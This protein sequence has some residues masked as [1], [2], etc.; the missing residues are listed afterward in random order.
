MQRILFQIVIPRDVSTFPQRTLWDQCYKSAFSKWRLALMIPTEPS[1]NGWTMFVSYFM[2]F[3]TEVYSVLVWYFR[4]TYFKTENHQHD[5]HPIRLSRTG[6]R[7]VS[8]ALHLL[9]T[10]HN[11]Q[12][13]FIERRVISFKRFISLTVSGQE[14]QLLRHLRLHGWKNVWVC[15]VAQVT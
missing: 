5:I 3:L 10:W 11:I 9:H 7:G 15:F 14:S 12:G 13:S 6:L 8:Q 2:P 4:S 1:N